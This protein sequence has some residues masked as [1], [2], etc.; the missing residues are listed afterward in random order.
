M[1]KTQKRRKFIKEIGIGSGT[2]LWSFPF[3]NFGCN[4][5]KETRETNETN[6]T[7]N[8]AKKLGIAL[9]GLGNYSS[10]QLAP[11]LQETKFCEL[12]GIVT[13]TPEKEKK[14]AD[15]YKIP[16]ENIY[17]Y[18][19][20]DKIIDNKDID[21]VYVVLP[22]SMHSEYV[23]RAAEAGKHV[24]CEKPMAIEVKECEEMIAACKKAGKKL[25]VGYRLHFEPY[26]R[27]M[28][29]LGQQK[30]HGDIKELESGFGFKIGDP[31]QWRLKKELSGGGPLMDV[32]I[33]AIQA[34]IYTL[35]ELPISVMAESKTVDTQKFKGVE[36]V[37]TWEFEFPSGIVVKSKSS[38]AD[39]YNFVKA[40]TE[41]ASFG[42]EPAYSYGGLKGY[43]NDKTMDFPDINQQAAQMDAF[44]QC[45]MEDKE[46]TVPG[47]MGMRDVE[48]LQA[49]Y[50]SAETGK[51]ISLDLKA[52]ILDKV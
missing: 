2:L 46:S 23:I 40:K 4:P 32:G 7:E 44:A 3:F 9:V 49:I 22:N 35:G 21:I 45:I 39:N 28:M 41:K 8:Q 20:F 14:W 17:N 34:A 16:K 50:Q 15:Q 30:I 42:L 31:T 12:R 11:A 10:G 19:T 6:N 26:N 36:E 5:K 48:L 13:G 18:K 1:M 29:R 33:Y 52:K 25:S 24:I 51:K 43:V 27:E 37:I 38:Y 47:E